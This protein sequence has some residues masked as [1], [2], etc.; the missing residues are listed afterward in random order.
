MRML[1]E[2]LGQLTFF[3]F[4]ILLTN[5]H[6]HPSITYISLKKELL[7]QL[8]SHGLVNKTKRHLDR[9]HYVVQH[10]S[11][12]FFL[13]YFLHIR[14]LLKQNGKG[15]GKANLVVQSVKLK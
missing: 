9:L 14:N 8:I 6:I 13:L 1:N 10:K 4:L 15:N 12:F 5:L 3:F 7:D 2:Q 11:T